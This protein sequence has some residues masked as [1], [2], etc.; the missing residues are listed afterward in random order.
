MAERYLLDT[1]AVLAAWQGEPG[2][3]DVKALLE[4]VAAGNC[5]IFTS[6]M[7]FFE[8][9]YVTKRRTGEAKAIEIYNW[10]HRLPI[11]RVDLEE[12]GILISAADIKSQH[13]V[14]AIDAWIIATGLAKAAAIVHKDEEFDRLINLPVT[15]VKIPRV[16]KQ[17]GSAP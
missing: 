14:S 5:E 12:E 4:Q 7:T 17:E 2:E 15:F 3:R 1:S 11:Q 10:L 6:F 8:A 16:A 9:Y 13:S